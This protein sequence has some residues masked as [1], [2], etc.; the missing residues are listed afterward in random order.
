M[1]RL[2]QSIVALQ[3]AAY[4]LLPGCLCQIV[5]LLGL[6]D[7]SPRSSVEETYLVGDHPID[8]HCHEL[9]GKFAEA[10]DD[11]RLV[12]IPPP[13]PLR[14]PAM[15]EVP[16]GP[17]SGVLSARPPPSPALAEL[18]QASYLGVFLI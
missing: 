5:G 11:E 9:S 17:V 13:T 3:L 16:P 2:V 18:T 15:P 7:F 12:R 6:D 14:S 8:C 10:H 4:L 1:N